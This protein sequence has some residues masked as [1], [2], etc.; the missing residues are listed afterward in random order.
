MK[1]KHCPFCGFDDLDSDDPDII[2]PMN[3]EKTL[4]ILVC[5]ESYG[6]CNASVLGTSIEEC[7]QHWE[8][9]VIDN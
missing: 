7:I 2:Y 1:L 3:I 5:N 8:R 6:G 9:R 4:Y